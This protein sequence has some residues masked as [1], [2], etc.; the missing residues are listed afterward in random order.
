MKIRNLT[1]C[2][3]FT[4]LICVTAFIKIPTPLVPITLQ[5]QVVLL[6]GLLLGPRAGCTSTLLYMVLGL[7]GL[8]IFTGGGGLGYVF[9]PTFGYI[10]GFIPAAWLAGWLTYRG[11]CNFPR[12]LG[13]TLVGLAVIYLCGMGYYYIVGNY[14]TASPIGLWPLFLNFCLIFLPTDLLLGICCALLAYRLLPHLR[15]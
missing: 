9:H 13:A 4:A 12:L 2:G 7:V 10:A 11:R 3:V 1:L 8:P 14:L 6:A 15:R 5:S